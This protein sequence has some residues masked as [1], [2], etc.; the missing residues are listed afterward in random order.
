MLLNRLI[1]LKKKLSEDLVIAD[2]ALN[3]NLTLETVI[4]LA[5]VPICQVS[6]EGERL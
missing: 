4:S 2:A 5:S 1:L 3:K 6:G